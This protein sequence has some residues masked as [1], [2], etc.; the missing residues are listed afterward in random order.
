MK[1]L[2]EL[3]FSS[4]YEEV[5]KVESLLNVLQDKLDF[6]DEFYAK[7]ML[8]VSEAVTNA[9]VHGNNLDES[10]KVTLKSFLNDSDSKLIFETKDEGLGFDPNILPDPLSNENLLK[11]SGRGVFLMEEY[12]DEINYSEGGTKLTLVF[13][14]PK[15]SV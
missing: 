9:I 13:D 6:D 12:A 10:K 11:A 7:L 15:N 1:L 14:L 3:T 8:G 4:N 5:E 2:Q